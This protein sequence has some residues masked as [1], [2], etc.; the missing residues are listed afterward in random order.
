MLPSSALFLVSA[1][2][3]LSPQEGHSLPFLNPFLMGV[4]EYGASGLA[5]GVP[6]GL[7]GGPMGNL[8]T[9][10]RAAS[11]T[12]LFEAKQEGNRQLAKASVLTGEE[13]KL[14]AQKD[15]ALWQSLQYNQGPQASSTKEDDPSIPDPL[16]TKPSSFS[17]SSSSSPTTLTSDIEAQDADSLTLMNL[18]V[19]TSFLMLFQR[20]IHF[21]EPKK[22]WC[23]QRGAPAFSVLAFPKHMLN[24]GAGG[25]GQVLVIKDPLM[26]YQSIIHQTEEL[27]KADQ[28]KKL[29][30]DN[31]ASQKKVMDAAAK[32]HVQWHVS[33]GN[34]LPSS[35]KKGGYTANP[36]H[37][38][39]N[40]D[41]D[42][43]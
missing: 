30:N 18:D 40:Q 16:I 8:Y 7:L 11:D 21:L 9:Y 10:K 28:I 35:S 34:G 23:I 15:A 4:V 2:T 1:L 25:L 43:D 42:M 24:L 5:W 26:I 32:K 20:V 27:Q 29:P 39:I 38:T 14:Q 6:S 31:D 13:A 3:L 22:S 33:G 41:A 37:P 12:E 36:I 19:D 17:S